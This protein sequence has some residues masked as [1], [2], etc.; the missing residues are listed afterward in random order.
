MAAK[1]KVDISRELLD[2]FW[3]DPIGPLAREVERRGDR[4]HLAIRGETPRMTGLL[5]AT[6]RK[7]PLAFSRSSASQVSMT[8]TVGSSSLTPY[9]GYILDGTVPHII[10][11]RGAHMVKVFEGPEI[12]GHKVKRKRVQNTHLRF[13]SGGR[14]VF[15]TVVHHPGTKSNDFITRGLEMG[16]GA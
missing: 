12:K 9:L 2:A 10:T 6:V 8:I 16:F 3:M 5:A 4:V 13:V 14:V 15:A 1:V 7:Q 11:P